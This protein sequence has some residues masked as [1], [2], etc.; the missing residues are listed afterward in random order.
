MRCFHLILVGLILI[1]IWSASGTNVEDQE[2][3]CE[4]L[5]ANKEC[6]KTLTDCCKN[7]LAMGGNR[8]TAN[9]ILKNPNCSPRTQGAIAYES[10]PYDFLLSSY[11]ES[12][13]KDRNDTWA[14]NEKGIALGELNRLDESIACFD[15]VIRIE[16]STSEIAVAWNNIGV[17][18]DK[19]D[20]HD[21]ALEA[22]NNSIQINPSLAEA[23]HNKGKTLSLNIDAYDA[24]HE[25]DQN[26][27]RITPKLNGGVG[28]IYAEF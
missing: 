21:E 19:M 22:Y 27:L 7:Y 15:E 23:W 24:A 13:A 16:N 11:N 9:K 26:A 25:C 4:K 3:K 20:R 12:I 10:E 14:W 5:V 2:K 17:S 18:M 1:V 6:D 28:W 8:N